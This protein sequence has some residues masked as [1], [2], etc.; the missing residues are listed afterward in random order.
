MNTKILVAV[1]GSPASEK[2][3][4]WALA[5]CSTNP[6]VTFT[7]LTVY[8]PYPP[9]VMS[10]GMVPMAYE[11]IAYEQPEHSPAQKAWERFPDKSRVDYKTVTG[12]PANVIC[13]MAEEE[14]YGLIVLGSQGHGLVASALLGS[15]SSKVLHHAPC[16]VLIVR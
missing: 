11:P 9:V 1:D 15:V 10:P 2:A 4:E 7:I 5:T 12:I 8:Q 13:Q 16:S 3:V 6:D 14:G